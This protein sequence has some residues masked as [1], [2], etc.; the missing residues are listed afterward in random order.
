[1][2]PVGIFF[3]YLEKLGHCSLQDLE[4]WAWAQESCAL[5]SLP[6]FQRFP[7]S[8]PF[9]GPVKMDLKTV[10]FPESFEAFRQHSASSTDYLGY[11]GFGVVKPQLSRNTSD[12]IEYGCKSFKQALHILPVEQLKISLVAVGEMTP[13]GTYL[14]IFCHFRKKSA[15]P[16]STCAFTGLV[17]QRYASR[18]S[19]TEDL[20]VLNGI[21]LGYRSVR[22]IERIKFFSSAF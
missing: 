16:K 2:V 9:P 22:T 3:A 6:C 15:A 18:F 17:L 10:V 5:S 7:F 14:S 8:W 4:T 1:M 11:N 19:H 12:M 13:Q 20:F 21:I